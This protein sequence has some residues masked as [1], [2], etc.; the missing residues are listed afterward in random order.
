MPDI[1]ENKTG[2]AQVKE[3][4]HQEW[5]VE[6]I[7][8]TNGIEIHIQ[9]GAYPYKGMATPEAIHAINTVK[10]LCLEMLRL[11]PLRKPQNV[12][13]SFDKV[14]DSVIRPY[15]IKREYMT[16]FAREIRTFIEIFL[17]ELGFDYGQIPATISHIFEYDAAYRFRFQ[18][19][20][21]ETTKEKLMNNPLKEL[22]RL[23]DLLKERDYPEMVEKFRKVEYVGWLL[24][25][26]KIKKAFRTALEQSTFENLQFD[27]SD[28]YW[29]CFK[30]DYDY[31]GKT[32]GERT[33]MLIE[34]N[35]PVPPSQPIQR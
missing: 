34:K 2:E 13:R 32:L 1:F 28:R 31:F 4:A 11:R 29:A 15:I 12:L 19:L 17:Q 35:L 7:D 9:G 8:Y 6:N 25:L 21:S 33:L 3:E 24:V 27:E 14:S 22:Q 10:T 23:F 16:P 30:F 5:I 26:P 18:D 20:F